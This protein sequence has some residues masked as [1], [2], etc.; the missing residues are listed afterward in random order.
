M[1]WQISGDFFDRDSCVQCGVCFHRCPVLKLPIEEAKKEIKR[2]VEGERTKH[3]LQKCTSC[4]ACNF[5]CPQNCNPYGLI[6]NRWYETY[7]KE[8]LAIKRTFSLPCQP[9]NLWSAMYKGLPDG[10][11]KMLQSWS[12]LPESDEV[13]YAGCA[14]LLFPYL[15]Q[16]RLF[17]NVAIMGSEEF[18]EGGMYYQMGLLNI[19]E[20]FAKRIEKIFKGLGVKK[21][22]TFCPTCDNMFKIILPKYFGVKF[23]FE[24]QFITEWLW[25]RI[26]NGIIEIKSKLNKTVAIQESCHSKVLGTNLLD[27]PR[28]ILEAI[29]AKVIEMKRTKEDAL[30]CGMGAVSIHF[31]LPKMALSGIRQ[32]REASKTQAEIFLSYCPGCLLILAAMRRLYPSKI[33]LYHILELV[34]LATDEKPV[35][36]H[37]EMA[38]QALKAVILKGVPNIFSRKRISLE[39]MMNRLTC[40]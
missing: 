23:D 35:H 14:T 9:N 25:E 30:C 13:L 27:I 4:S 3:V 2:L 26:E 40:L 38:G 11:K 8:G 6:L 36:R 10:E 1:V 7:K 21:V 20:L 17:D 16:T 33:P 29:G 37:S 32:W 5:F 28:K 24:I 15:F 12:K 19:V 39:E 18:C 22:I 34:Q 31:D